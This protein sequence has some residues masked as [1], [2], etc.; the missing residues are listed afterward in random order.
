MTPKGAHGRSNK[1]FYYTCCKQVHLGGRQACPAPSLPAESL[2]KAVLARLNE[3]GSQETARQKIIEAA[4]KLLDV[5]AE[6]T[7]RDM[8]AVK[9]RLGSI[10]SEIQNLLGVLKALGQQGLTTVQG[11]LVR[12][13]GEQSTLRE[14]LTQLTQ[15]RAPADA[16]TE[17]ARQFIQ[18]WRGIDDLLAEATPQERQLLLQHLIEVIELRPTDDPRQGEYA[19]RLW[20]EVPSFDNSNSG[21][22]L[23]QNDSQTTDDSPLTEPPL[24]RRVSEKAPRVGLEPTTNRLTAGCS[25]IELS[26]NMASQQGTC[27]VLSHR[28]CLDKPSSTSSRLSGVRHGL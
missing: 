13:E 1:H 2:E 26:G 17:A 15:R 4:L 16:A 10:Q 12:L 28:A 7:S 25:T 18:S 6:Q 23:R 22:E 27:T 21:K 24:V 11:E 8:D 5:D 20:P 14:R 9:S 19:L 3:L